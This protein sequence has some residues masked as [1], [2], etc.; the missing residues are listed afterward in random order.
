MELSNCSS[1]YPASIPP[2]SLDHSHWCRDILLYPKTKTLL[3]PQP[4]SAVTLILCS[5]LQQSPQNC[6]LYSL[7][8]FLSFQTVLKAL[9]PGFLLTMPPPPIW[10]C[11]CHHL[12]Y[13]AWAFDA[14]DSSFLPNT[15]FIRLLGFYD[16][17]N[18]LQLSGLPSSSQPLNVGVFQGW[19]LGSFFFSLW[20]TC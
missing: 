3:T 16:L 5:S 10:S 11:H 2:S 12:F 4:S 1:L 19:V 8:L 9:Q 15:F 20:L 14:V 6:C 17:L 13:L 7:S 18:F